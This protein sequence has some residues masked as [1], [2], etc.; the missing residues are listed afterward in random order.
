MISIM[1]RW[2]LKRRSP[3]PV[4][5]LST[6]PPERAVFCYDTVKSRK[7]MPV[8]IEIKGNLARLLATENLI[9][10]HKQVETAM[11]DV[12]RRVLTLPMWQ[13]ASNHV[14][15]MLVAHEVGHALFTPFREWNFEEN[16]KDVPPDYVNVVEDARIE[17]LMKNKFAGLSRDF[18][19]AYNELHHD[20]FFGVK[21]EDINRMKLIDKINLY[22]KIGAYLCIDFEDDEE[23]FVTEI[24]KAET[25]EQVLDISKRIHEYAKQQHKQKKV[26]PQ[27]SQ[28]DVSDGHQTSQQPQSSTDGVNDKNDFENLEQNN[29]SIKEGKSEVGNKK[30]EKPEANPNS[31]DEGDLDKSDTQQSFSNKSS[32]LIDR[33]LNET[34]YV[35]VPELNID[36][37]VVDFDTVKKYLDLHYQDE[38]LVNSAREDRIKEEIQR[39]IQFKNS[40]AKEVNY[41]VK[42]FEMK[43]SAD[44]YARVTTSRTGI[45]NTGKLHSYKYNEDLFKKVTTIPE[46][47][48]HGLVFYLDWSGSMQHIMLDTMKQL[49][50]LVWFCRKVNIP[51]D[52]YAFTNNSHSLNIGDNTTPVHDISKMDVCKEWKENDIN[53]DGCFRMVNILNS[54]VKNADL[55]KMMQNLWLTAKSFSS[56]HYEYPLRFSLG[57]TPLNECIIASAQ[58]MQQFINKHKV[59]KCHAIVLTDGEGYSPSYNLIRKTHFDSAAKKGRGRIYQNTVIR[60]PRNGRTY[61]PQN[62]E[63]DFT[64][65]LIEYVKDDVPGVSFVGFRVLE[66]GSLSNFFNWY[67]INSQYTNIDEMRNDLKK[68]NSLCI[69]TKAFD[70]FFGLQQSSL[71]VDAD[72]KVED[73]ASKREISNAFRKMFKGKKTNKFVL[74]TFVKQIA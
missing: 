47:K 2:H 12:D 40:A 7:A 48:N 10:E 19:A 73:D 25:F 18:Y 1:L 41:L 39:Y 69:K 37:V 70:L 22:F 44:A 35:G 51:F 6:K 29:N 11:F 65:K 62:T 28:D 67:G 66:R 63:G 55:N 16:Y 58:L 21:D 60:N 15:D 46:G 23:Q 26:Q 27:E 20:N 38:A 52:V 9:V 71:S 3:E 56:S 32:D 45:L 4:F 50:Q 24:V 68:N 59:Q 43:K 64:N 33:R 53:I 72:L 57:G 49:F 14:Y 17:R 13:K 42:E 74:Q 8:N 31:E 36:N 30:V 54:N 34:L 5:K 61:S